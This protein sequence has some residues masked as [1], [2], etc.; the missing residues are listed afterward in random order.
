[1]LYAQ[2]PIEKAARRELVSCARK[3]EAAAGLSARSSLA[4]CSPAIGAGDGGKRQTERCALA[5][6]QVGQGNAVGCEA[7]KLCKLVDTV[8]K[9][10]QAPAGRNI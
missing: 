10:V 5:G 1:M 9:G 8:L 7:G 3:T 4:L 6:D 2:P